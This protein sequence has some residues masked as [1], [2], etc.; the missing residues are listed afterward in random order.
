MS[1]EKNFLDAKAYYLRLRRNLLKKE[2]ASNMDEP[3]LLVSQVLDIFRFSINQYTYEKET[4][5]LI[6]VSP[7]DSLDVSI[8]FLVKDSAGSFRFEGRTGKYA[9]TSDM[10]Y[11]N[12]ELKLA[13]ERA[14]R[15]RFS[16]E[17]F[18]EFLKI[19]SEHCTIDKEFAHLGWYFIQLK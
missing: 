4:E 16:K 15:E 14:N 11:M 18:Q 1:I 12:V 8:E 10:K 3:Y 7:E 19:I 5:I 9:R 6:E 13:L 2:K 17:K